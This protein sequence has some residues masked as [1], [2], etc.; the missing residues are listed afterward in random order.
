MQIVRFG[1]GGAPGPFGGHL[2]TGRPLQRPRGGNDLSQNDLFLSHF[3]PYRT[4]CSSVGGDRSRDVSNVRRYAGPAYGDLE[5][6]RR[7]LFSYAVGVGVRT[8][9]GKDVGLREPTKQGG[10]LLNKAGTY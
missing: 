10:S 6:V 3:C 4:G 2:G 9:G 5:I 1:G 8:P 7:A